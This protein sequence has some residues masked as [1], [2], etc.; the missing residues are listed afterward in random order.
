MKRYTLDHEYGGSEWTGSADM[1]DDPEGEWRKNSDVEQLEAEVHKLR[2]NLHKYFNHLPWCS[3]V[4]KPVTKKCDCG[5]VEAL[6][7]PKDK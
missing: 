1:I 7:P 5:L 2:I 3:H 6:S 4:K